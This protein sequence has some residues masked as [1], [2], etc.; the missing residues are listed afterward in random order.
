MS[1]TKFTRD[2]EWLRLEEDG[3]IT[4]GITDYA[5]DQLGDVVY[6]ELPETGTRFE[7]G[8]DMA[9]VESVKAAGEVNVPLAGEVIEVNTRL[10]EEPELV[11]S[12][13]LDDGWFIRI[14]PDDAGDL[15]EL[16]DEAEYRD[17]ID[18]L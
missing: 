1:N 13:P 7:A 8:K 4:V 16:M 14:N 10:A 11:N 5:Q 6:V 9:V 12:D 17:Y 18:D 2:H 15:Q 3:T